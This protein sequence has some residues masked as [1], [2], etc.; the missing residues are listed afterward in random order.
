[1]ATLFYYVG[2][3]GAGKSTIAAQRM[4]PSSLFLD[5]DMLRA[6]LLSDEGDQSNNALIFNE[7]LNRSVQALNTGRDVVYVACNIWSKKRIQFLKELRRRVRPPFVANCIVVDAP[8]NLC[9]ARNSARSRVVP[10]YVIDRQLRQFEIPYKGE[11]WDDIE[12]CRNYDEIASRN[13]LN[14]YVQRVKDFGSQ[15]NEHHSL[16]LFDHNYMTGSLAS[17]NNRFDI[18]EAGFKHDWGKVFT[19][20][21]WEKDNGKNAHYPNHAN[22]GAVM[23]MNTGADLHT[24]QLIN[25]HMLFYTDA[26]QQESWANRLGEQLWADLKLLHKYDEEAH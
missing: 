21:Y 7:M 14:D 2:I 5:S 13:C 17:M 12:L 10:S 22:V 16:S 19:Q 15:K 3:V 20:E 4:S 8:I 25:Y 1:M 6:E 11:G 26:R 23:A 24:I 9:R 18:A